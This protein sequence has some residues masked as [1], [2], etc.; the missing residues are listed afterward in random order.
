[1]IIWQI[2]V[3]AGYFVKGIAGFGNSL[4]HAGIMAFFK[5]N[6]V[7]TPVDSML[8]LPANVTMTWK[9]RQW[10]DKKIWLPAALISGLFLVP[11][12]LLLRNMDG[13]AVK[14]IFGFVVLALSLDMLRSKD[15]VPAA[16]TGRA[17]VMHWI[18]V[19]LSGVLSGMFGVGALMAAALTK[20]T[21]DSKELKAN[22]SAVYASTDVLRVIIYAATGLLTGPLALQGLI[23]MPAMLLGLFLGIRCA[24]K[25][26]ERSVRMCIILVLVGSGLTLILNNL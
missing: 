17:K 6:A 25:L 1:M 14:L 3:F 26:S 19:V 2:A 5:D 9:H 23:L 16:P 15:K 18:T 22:L 12:A 20:T 4:I 24:G 7:I 8:T 13:R 10:L 11:G 21:R